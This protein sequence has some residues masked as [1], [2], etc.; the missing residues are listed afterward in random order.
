M[1]WRSRKA[2][3]FPPYCLAF[4]CGVLAFYGVGAWELIM[5]WEHGVRVLLISGRLSRGSGSSGVNLHLER[6]PKTMDM[7]SASV[8]F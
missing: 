7:C 2:C 6:Y 1:C 4:L 3:H 8:A 5:Y